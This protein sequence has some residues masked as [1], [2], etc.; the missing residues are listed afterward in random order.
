M[1]RCSSTKVASAIWLRILTSESLQ[2]NSKGLRFPVLGSWFL[3]STS[4]PEDPGTQLLPRGG[5]KAIGTKPLTRT[6]GIR[7][8]QFWAQRLA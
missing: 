1:T 5:T 4:V 3:G 7:A 8:E 2:F 6:M